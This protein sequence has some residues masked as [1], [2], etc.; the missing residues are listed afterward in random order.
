MKKIVFLIM[1][2]FSFIGCSP[3]SPAIENNEEDIINDTINV[4]YNSKCS[5]VQCYGTTK[6]GKRCKN[7]TT[8]CSGYCYLHN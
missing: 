3:N 7:R 6:K 8:N 4:H 1:V 5:S 2:I